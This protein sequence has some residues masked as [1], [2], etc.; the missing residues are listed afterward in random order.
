MPK[1]VCIVGA[2]PSGLLA[3]KNLLCNAPKDHFK[4]TV[5]DAHD[6]IGGLWPTS[7]TDTTRQ[8]HPTMVANQSKHTMQF[9]DHAWE[10]GA[11]QLPLAWQVGRYLEQYMARYLS[12][13]SGFNLRL[14]TRVVQAKRAGEDG[15]GWD[16]CLESEGKG[17]TQHFEYLVVASGYFGKPIVSEGM[18][19]SPSAAVPVIHSSQYRDLKSLLG[20][21]GSAK[22]K[23]LV[24][25]G[26]MSGVEVAGTIASHLSSAVNSPHHS[27]IP[28]ID[29]CSIHH[30]IQRPI[31]V[32]AAAA[33]FLPLDFSSYNRNNR[34]LPLINTQGHV[35]KQS[36]Q[37]FNG[38]FQAALGTDQ[39]V[40]SS[41]L[42]V[43]DVMTTQPPYLAVSDWYCDFVRSHFI[44][45]SNARFESLDGNTAKLTDG[46]EIKDVIAVVLATGFDPSPC[47]SYLP[48]DVLKTLKHSPHHTEQPLA[49]AF[50]GTHHPDVPGLGFVGFYR[51]PYWGVMQM[52]ARFLADYWSTPK[53]ALPRALSSKMKSD[54]SI[55]RTLDLRGD[56]RLSQFPM[57]DYPF[58]MQEFSE[59]LSIPRIDPS[60]SGIPTLSYNSLP[61]DMLTPARYPSPSDDASA[62]KDAEKSRQDT[63]QVTIDGLTTAR[64]VPRAV[65]RSLLGT[66]KLERDLSSRLATHPTGHF[67]GTA[68]FLLRDK[69]SDGLQC[70]R[71]YSELSDAD[72]DGGM[73]YLYVEE[74]EF[75]TEQDVRFRASRR[76]VWRYDENKESLSVWFAKPEDPKRADYLF[77]EIEFL[78]PETGREKG[79]PAKAGHLCID[80]YYDV[81]Y[82]FAFETV[83]LK[84]WSIE[85]TVNGPKKDYTIRGVYTR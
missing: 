31:W 10:D 1:S 40:F 18:S 21:R 39:S 37:I 33:P 82:N 66:W 79:W 29:Q 53:D 56:P 47:I 65:F 61:L 26:Q 55:Q 77:H 6:A 46:T 84:R 49:L 60:L 42:H 70:A 32:K 20:A 43:D 80:D 78:N 74:G 35:S 34:P 22:G 71:Q 81:K 75:K 2:G 58:L 23:I 69:T 8:V 5:F 9:S 13:H 45:L 48:S 50:H 52:Q 44:S 63:V 15:S 4:V 73:E 19:I 85:Y 14:N 16:V 51:S 30:V 76:Y 36:A 11:P 41:L 3:A 12:S 28:D 64:F 83:N 27:S 17:Q 24:V 62:K 67:S 25:G 7:K 57:G 72:A 59:A 38:L 54:T 68:Q